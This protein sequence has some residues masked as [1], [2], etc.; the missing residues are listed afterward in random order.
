[1][2]LAVSSDSCDALNRHSSQA[3]TIVLYPA[4]LALLGSALMT[5]HAVTVYSQI[6]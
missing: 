3:S 5:T 6:S 4:G 1:M 2:G